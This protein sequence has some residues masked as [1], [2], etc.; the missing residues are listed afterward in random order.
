MTHRP[1]GAQGS[2]RPVAQALARVSLA[3]G[4]VS[5]FGVIT[6]A[7]YRARLLS[8]SIIVASLGMGIIGVFSPRRGVA[9][10]GIVLSLFALLQL[11]VPIG[12]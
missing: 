12:R 11:L 2:A 5:T 1:G 6:T 9:A 10:S 3:L 7:A 8:A 4:I